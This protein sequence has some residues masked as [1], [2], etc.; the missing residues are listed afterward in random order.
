MQGLFDADAAEGLTAVE[1]IGVEFL[2][3]EFAANLADHRRLETEAI[4]HG[5]DVFDG[6]ND[7]ADD[8]DDDADDA[9]PGNS[10]GNSGNGGGNGNGRGNNR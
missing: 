2:D 10:G 1:R 8:G 5:V 9:V 6:V 7:D 4:D 3:D